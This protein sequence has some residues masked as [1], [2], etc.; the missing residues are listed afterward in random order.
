VIQFETLS[1]ERL[2]GLS[3]PGNEHYDPSL[4]RKIPAA[5]FLA[6]RNAREL[7]TGHDV[8]LAG[9]ITCTETP[10]A[11]TQVVLEAQMVAQ[12]DPV[13]AILGG[14]RMKESI[15]TSMKHLK[16]MRHHTDSRSARSR[17]G[18]GRSAHTSSSSLSTSFGFLPRATSTRGGSTGVGD[19][20]YKLE[21]A[22]ILTHLCSC[23][24]D[25]HEHFARYAA[26]E[27]AEQRHFIDVTLA[28]ELLPMSYT[29][30]EM[31]KTSMH[32]CEKKWARQ[33]NTLDME[34]EYFHHL[35][36]GEAAWAKGRAKV[37][38]SAAN[39]TSWLWHSMTKVSTVYNIRR[40][41]TTTT[42]DD[43]I[44]RQHPTTS[45]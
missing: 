30:E 19:M 39:A 17:A 6:V 41:H 1:K 22:S 16:D 36:A 28:S 7:S 35:E 10:F 15:R 14:G 45:A 32:F 20:P 8:P 23:V 11:T 25:L 18:S 5:H 31:V 34:C 13:A 43:N 2:E 3:I 9:F 21:A 4:F 40:Q 44:R 26:V 37:D 38:A 42:Y 24:L 29:E 33:S 12:P 27:A